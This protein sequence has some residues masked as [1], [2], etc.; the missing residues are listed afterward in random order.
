MQVWFPVIDSTRCIGC[1]VCV[2]QCPT[3]ALGSLNHQAVLV[4]P[5]NCIYCSTCETICPQ[6]AVALPYLICFQGQC[7]GE[8]HE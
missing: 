1:M 4:N 8:D 7:G 6:D 5:D 3:G 2:G